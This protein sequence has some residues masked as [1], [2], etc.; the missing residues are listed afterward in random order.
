MTIRQLSASDTYPLRH[1][2]LRK[3]RPLEDCAFDS[4]DLRTTV[5]IGSYLESTLVGVASFMLDKDN[6]ISLLKNIDK[7]H[8]YQLRGMAVLEQLQGHHVGTR[9]LQYGEQLLREKDCSHLWFNARELA[10]PFYHKLGYT[11]VSDIFEIISVGKH[12][13]MYKAL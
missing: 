11:I 13:K 3:G 8:C 1:A 9:L 6:S 12:C 4:D 10:V 2:V 7:K 5:H